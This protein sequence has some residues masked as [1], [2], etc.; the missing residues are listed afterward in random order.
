MTSEPHTSFDAVQDFL[1]ARRR[2]GLTEV[3]AVLSGREAPLLSYDEVRRRLHAVETPTQK[4][5]DVPLDAIVGSVG[6]TQDFTR[7]FLPRSDADKAR[8]V[9]VRVAMT[10]LSG[11]PPVDLYRIG[12]AYFVR[13]GNHRVSVARQLG[14]KFIQACD[15][16]QS[17]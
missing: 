8:W 11:T 7:E 13:D 12:D 14:A 9:G 5:E 1:R 16:R 2:A 17:G 4:L 3:L 15:R 10:G 6:R